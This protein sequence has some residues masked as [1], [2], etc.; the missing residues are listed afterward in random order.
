LAA[1]YGNNSKEYVLKG[2]KGKA[3]IP[4]KR[5]ANEVP[6]DPKMPMFPFLPSH[7]PHSYKKHSRGKSVYIS[8]PNIKF[9]KIAV[10]CNHKEYSPHK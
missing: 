5:Y 6:Y 4:I 2:G 10:H 8:S 1:K 7:K 3:F 9:V